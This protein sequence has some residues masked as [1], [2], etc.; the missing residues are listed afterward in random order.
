LLSLV[1]L[2]NFSTASVSRLSLARDA[3]FAFNS[4]FASSLHGGQKVVPLAATPEHVRQ[5]LDLYDFVSLGPV[6]SSRL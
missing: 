2:K 1:A 3:L 6:V 5:L 4:S